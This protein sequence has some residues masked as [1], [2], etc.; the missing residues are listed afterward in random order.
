MNQGEKFD[1]EI[2][3]H[4]KQRMKLYGI[5]ESDI[6]YVIANGVKSDLGENKFSYIANIKSHKFPLKVVCKIRNEE[7]LIITSF[8]LKRGL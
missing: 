6:N 7:C 8:P 2:S 3:R 1:V 5:N 4:A